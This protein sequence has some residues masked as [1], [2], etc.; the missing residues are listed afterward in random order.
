MEVK[1]CLVCL[2]SLQP[3]VCRLR[4]SKEGG[5]SHWIIGVG[6]GWDPSWRTRVDESF[7]RFIHCEGMGLRSLM[8]APRVLLLIP[9][10]P[11]ESAPLFH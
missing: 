7:L 11:K 10:D 9:I 5:D 1:A 4:W 2:A 3:V 6:E 8:G